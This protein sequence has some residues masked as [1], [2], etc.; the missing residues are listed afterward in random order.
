MNLQ[1]HEQ[2]TV[3]QIQVA[4]TIRN[5]DAIKKLQPHLKGL[6]REAAVIKIA[7]NRQVSSQLWI[8][9][10]RCKNPLHEVSSVLVSDQ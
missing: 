9:F 3:E 10:G 7:K 1:Y 4:L 5:F 6:E 2:R 8:T